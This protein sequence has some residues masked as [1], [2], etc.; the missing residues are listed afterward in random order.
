MATDLKLQVT[1]A[2]FG[3]NMKLHLTWDEATRIFNVLANELIKHY[4]CGESTGCLTC[5]VGAAHEE[6]PC[7]SNA[8]D[9]GARAAEEK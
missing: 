7:L 1:D 2:E 6:L 8:F 3:P 9:A 4:H 5:D